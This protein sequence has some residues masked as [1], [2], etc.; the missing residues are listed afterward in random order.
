M[1]KLLTESTINYNAETYGDAVNYLKYRYKQLRKFGIRMS[2]ERYTCDDKS[3]ITHYKSPIGNWD[4]LYLLKGATGQGNYERLV[5]KH[6]LKIVTLEECGLEDYLKAKNIEHIMLKHSPAY[7]LVQE[8]YG[9]Q[10][11]KRSGVPYIYHIDEGLAILE[12]IGAS[13]NTKEAYCLHPILQMDKDFTKNKDMDFSGI[14][15]EAIILAMEYRRVAN[16]YLSKSHPSEFV[17]FSCPEVREMLI[18]D[19][20]QNYKDFISYQKDLANQIELFEYFDY[21]FELLKV[22]YSELVKVIL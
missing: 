8:F 2:M 7:K 11:A 3:I 15:T 20:V 19:K 9:D 14:E 16:S 12:H 10:R 17:G 5:K 4:S 22:D 1:K 13:Y 21:W 6:K 18:A